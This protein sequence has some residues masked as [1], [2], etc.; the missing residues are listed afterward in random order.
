MESIQRLEVEELLDEGLDE[1]V[2]GRPQYVPAAAVLDDYDLFDARF[3]GFG[4]REAALL[5]PQHRLFLECAWHA[6]EN[7]CVPPGT[8]SRGGVFAGAGVPGYLMSNLLCGRRA[9]LDSEFFELQIHNDKDYLATRVAHR[10]GFTGPAISVQTACSSSL[11]AVHEAAAALA[12]GT[13]DIAVAGGVCVRVP[14]RVGYLHEQGMIF[15]ADGHCRPFDARASGTVFGSGVGAVVLKR[16]SD[17]LA[18]GN[19]ILAVVKG[20]AVNNDGAGKVGFTAP[21]VAGQE[22]VVRAAIRAA[23]VPAATI[24]AVEAHGTATPVGDPIEIAALT[25][26][27]DTTRVGFCTVGS[28]KSNI[29]HLESAAG[30]AGFI[31]AVLQLRLRTLVPTLHYSEA[32]PAIDFGRTPFVVATEQTDWLSGDSPRRIGVSAFGIGG[33]NAHVVLEEAPEVTPAPRSPGPQL[34]VISGKTRQAVDEY[35]NALADAL[36]QAGAPHLADASRTLREGRAALRFR[37]AVVLSAGSEPEELSALRT[38]G[39]SVRQGTPET[40][41]TFPGQGTQYPG[42]CARLYEA[43]PSYARRVDDCVAQLGP[44]L[45]TDVRRALLDET[46]DAG[47]LRDTHLAQP[48]LFVAEFALAEQLRAWGATPSVV[49]GHSLGEITAACVAGVLSLPDALRLVAK[50][51]ALMAA[52]PPGVML[53]VEAEESEVTRL[54]P[55]GVQLAAVNAARL[56]VVAGPAER[57]GSFRERLARERVPCRELHTSH[58]FHSAM[59]EPVVEPLAEVVAGL[60]LTAPTVPFVTAT[61]GGPATNDPR[62]PLYWA[63]QVVRPVHFAAALRRA[64]PVGADTL[65]VEVGPGAVLS[66]FA[67]ATYGTGTPTVRTMAGPDAVGR[68]V[69]VLVA[70]VGKLWECGCPVE[71][72]ELPGAGGNLI[73]LPGY[74]F[75]RQRH[76]ISPDPEHRARPRPAR[77]APGEAIPAAEQV[78]QRPAGMASSYSDP[79]TELQKQIVSVWEDIL[80][81]SPI[82]AHDDFFELGGHS[83]LAARVSARLT[84]VTGIPFS[85]HDVMTRPTPAKLADSAARVDGTDTSRAVLDGKDHS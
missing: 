66:T 71:L 41:W 25:R 40:V 49:V 1:S 81:Y 55:R 74:A 15:S 70:A 28:I 32:N 6:M 23:D 43:L 8:T 30:I 58:A 51:G 38:G 85:L 82:G 45:G 19:R 10:L 63:R 80:Q 68:G 35:G 57:V 9:I 3:F 12:S 16:L 36:E 29:G 11:V 76:W 37:R 33:T 50:R 42:M 4:A 53:A 52:Q 31:K 67:R 5:D 17:A 22:A 26:A 48:A 72:G 18:D 27:F 39:Q 62:D 79:E 83:L 46:F 73:D 24:T 59:M 34:L 44:Q 13:C 61:A 65:F 54:L 56:C 2:F 77:V 69:R 21:S 84:E 75:A 20:S 47:R 64:A 7:A 78:A 14:H 60:E